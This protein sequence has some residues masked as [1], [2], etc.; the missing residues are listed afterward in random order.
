MLQHSRRSLLHALALALAVNACTCGSEDSDNDAAPDE[1]D[2]CLAVANPDQADGDGDGVGDLCDA[3]PADPAA[4]HQAAGACDADGDG[5]ADAADNCPA[6]ANANQANADQDAPGDACDSDADN[7]GFPNDR[8][9]CR[10]V[11]NPLQEDRD[12][13]DAG[14]ACDNCPFE[15]NPTQ[16]DTTE[17]APDGAGDACDSC[18][19]A[20]DASNADSDGDG[21]GDVCDDDADNDGDPNSADNCPTVPNPGQE[22]ADTDGKGDAC[23]DCPGN[24]APTC[25]APPFSARSIFPSAG[26]RGAA[27]A[28]TVAGEGFEDPMTLTFKNIDDPGVLFLATGVTVTGPN[29]LSATVPADAVRPTGLYDVV[30]RRGTRTAT[31]AAAYVVSVYPPPR[32]SSATPPFAFQGLAGDGVLSDRSVTIRG[33]DF[34][35]TPEVR[36]IRLNTDRTASTDPADSFQS[37]YVGFIDSRSLTAVVPAESDSMRDGG[38]QVRVIN[39]DKQGDSWTEFVVKADPPPSIE[40]IEPPS[41]PSNQTPNLKVTGRNFKAGARAYLLELVSDDLDTALLLPPPIPISNPLGGVAVT[42]DSSTEVRFTIPSV[43]QGYYPIKIVNPDQQ[44]DIFFWYAA[45][46]SS[47]GKL[48]GN[49]TLTGVPGMN[50]ARERLSGTGAF[51]DFGNGYVYAVGGVGRLA[52]TGP[53]SVLDNVEVSQISILGRPGAW[54]LTQQMMP[55]WTSGPIHVEN[56]LDGA[57]D[58]DRP[59]QGHTVVRYGS[60]LYAIGGTRQNINTAGSVA[61]LTTILRTSVLGLENQPFLPNPRASGGQGLPYG[62][63]YYQVSSV[64]PEG[65]SIGSREALI[66]G[67]GRLTLRWSTV[68]CSDG[69]NARYNVYRSLASDGRSATTV[70]LNADGASTGVLLSGTAFE[71]RGQIAPAPGRLRGSAYD[72]GTD[73]PGLAAGDWVY[74]VAAV[75]DGQE[76]LAGYPLT[77]Q[78][79]SSL[80]GVSLRWDPLYRATYKVYRSLAGAPGGGTF[81]RATVLS[82]AFLDA[83]GAASAVNLNVT[84]REGERPLRPGD[85]YRW[86]TLRTHLREP[87]DGAEA[88]V[89]VAATDASSSEGMPLIYIAGG[90]RSN[91]AGAGDVLQTVEVARIN[92]LTGDLCPLTSVGACADADTELGFVTTAGGGAALMAEK[93]AYLA[94]VTSQGRAETPAPPEPKQPPTSCIDYDGDGHSDSSCGGDDCDDVDP[95]IHPGATEVCG[96][97]VDENCDGVAAACIC[98]NPEGGCGCPPENPTC[99]CIRTP[100]Q[101]C[102]C[103]P[104]TV[105]D[106]DGDGHLSY[107]C[108]GDDCNDGALTIH[109]GATEICGNGIDEDC[110]PANDSCNTICTTDA[111]SDGFL[112]IACGGTDCN[113]GDARIHPGAPEIPNDG[114]DQNCD[115]HDLIIVGSPG[116]RLPRGAIGSH[117]GIPTVAPPRDR[118]ILLLPVHGFA[119]NASTLSG[120]STF[121]VAEVVA[122]GRVTGFTL[123]SSTDNQGSA[124]GLEA[125]FYRAG[126]P[127]SSGGGVRP[128][129]K[130]WIFGG[131][132]NATIPAVSWSSTGTT[133]RFPVFAEE[134]YLEDGTGPSFSSMPANPAQIV[135]QFQ[136]AGS[137]GVPARSMFLG[138]RLFGRLIFV[139]GNTSSGPTRSVVVT[140]Q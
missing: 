103:G 84:P 28:V 118:Y 48:D 6:V 8:D 121:E 24:P 60:F 64:C 140:S 110:F 62:S 12:S 30:V 37:P 138:V 31:L 70:L 3:C 129:D 101:L 125:L 132:A 39:P 58:A 41:A 33:Q 50:Y 82:P 13:D 42:F 111:D 63:W 95:A 55:S 100:D 117:Q 49:S 47:D 122:G 93:R 78:T 23:D 68:R 115:G 69:S 120:S 56:R 104:G 67:G 25:S 106:A 52:D 9:N 14:D 66:D 127:K 26:W 77:V 40:A 54:R 87:R 51:D 105:V 114:V 36:F 21:V 99:G 102:H 76:T 16:A 134:R 15:S 34:I 11:A 20:A 27:I 81:L 4:A 96:N 85:T 43:S 2:N 89:V 5:V 35:A 46:S 128:N 71:D 116:L 72:A 88:V 131:S 59:R 57:S 44:F 53:V 1:A 113:D 22:D 124:F 75:I 61:G 94:F 17:G 109:P 91:A 139:G 90:R 130:L 97:D 65:E 80:R 133:N 18:P 137:F 108:G 29:G 73:G 86:K 74:R 38:Y 10:N 45:T 79:T 136:D 135:E 126:V 92:P 119:T 19:N 123:Q 107:T 98:V 7:D 32:I 112:A 83:D